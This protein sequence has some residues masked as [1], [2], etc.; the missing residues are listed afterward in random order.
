MP[1][2]AASNPGANLHARL[3]DT[4]QAH[5]GATSLHVAF[6]FDPGD[7]NRYGLVGFHLGV[8]DGDAVDLSGMDSLVLWAKGNGPVRVELVAIDGG[9]QRVY[10]KTATPGADWTRIVLRLTDFVSTTGG[11]AWAVASTR[12][13][14]VQFSVF[15]DSE[16]W[17]DDI[18]LFGKRLP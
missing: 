16:F 8:V 13:V 17:M 3:Y 9:V 4:T 10:A 1:D 7:Y 5:G 2:T 15:Q 6:A 14:R 12:A 18:R 11:G